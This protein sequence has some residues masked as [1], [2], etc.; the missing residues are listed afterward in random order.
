MEFYSEYKN[1][2][3]IIM[4]IV[5]FLLTV[6]CY[7]NSKKQPW[8]KYY[9]KG[10]FLLLMA[11]M[12]SSIKHIIAFPFLFGVLRTISMGIFIICGM[13]LISLGAKNQKQSRK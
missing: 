7:T 11:S 6:Y 4:N 12:F 8:F 9:W 1:I 10:F 3:A 13:Y 2:I 5:P